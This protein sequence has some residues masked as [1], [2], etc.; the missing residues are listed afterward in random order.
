MRGPCCQVQ[1]RG[2]QV[3]FAYPRA[4]KK[5]LRTHWVS[6][7]SQLQRHEHKPR[8]FAMDWTQ[9]SKTRQDFADESARAMALVKQIFG[10]NAH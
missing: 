6:M 4:R 9:A 5:A 2:V 3:S 1:G 10:T 7:L 8:G